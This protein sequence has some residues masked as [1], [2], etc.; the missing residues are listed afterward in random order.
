MGGPGTSKTTSWLN[1]A[2]WSVETNSPAR[3]Y[4]IDTD[5]TV[6]RMLNGQYAGVRDHLTT[7][8]ADHWS[9]YVDALAAISRYATPDDWVIVDMIGS[10]WPAVQEFFTEQVFNNDIG[11]YFLEARIAKEARDKTSGKK[12]QNLGA[13]DG[14]VDWQV[15][16]AMYNTWERRLLF[17]GKFNVLCCTPADPVNRDTDTAASIA[18]YGQYGLKPVGQ[19]LLGFHFSTVI[20]TE[21]RVNGQYTLTTVKDR[22]RPELEKARVEDFTET[23]LMD[24]AGWKV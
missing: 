23:Y 22:E 4:V 5:R 2:K 6:V 9:D 14:W 20:I 24:I 12:S 13:F 21:K 17:K 18:L 15:I 8:P 10:A 7:Y 16:N 3:F 19:K 1:I 11:N